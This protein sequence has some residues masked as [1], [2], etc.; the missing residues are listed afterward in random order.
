[1][2][3]VPLFATNAV[4][5]SHSAQGTPSNGHMTDFPFTTTAI[6]AVSALP[7]LVNFWVPESAFAPGLTM[8]FHT[9][10][11]CPVQDDYKPLKTKVSELQ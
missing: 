1:M 6:I 10:I 9:L 5:G 7:P 2:V 4:P 11:A 8:T 3:V